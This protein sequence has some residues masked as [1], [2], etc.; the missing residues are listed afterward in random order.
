MV[1]QQ[2]LAADRDQRLRQAGIG[3]AHAHALAA[4]DDRQVAD[5]VGRGEAQP[6][7][8]SASSSA[9]RRT[10]SS[11][12]SVGRRAEPG[13][14]RDGV[15][16]PRHV[17]HPAAVAAG[18]GDRRAGGHA[19]DHRLGQ[20]AD[21]R[22]GALRADVEE[23]PPLGRIRH[24]EPHRADQLGDVQVGL[25]LRAVAQHPQRG[26]SAGEAPREVDQRAVRAAR[27]DHVRKAEDPEA[28]EN[29]WIR[30][31]R[32]GSYVI[33]AVPLRQ[34]LGKLADIDPESSQLKHIKSCLAFTEQTINILIISKSSLKQSLDLLAIAVLYDAIE[35]SLGMRKD[36]YRAG[37]RLALGAGEH[38]QTQMPEDGWCTHDVHRVAHQFDL[39]S[40]YLS[41]NLDRPEPQTSHRN[42][43]AQACKAFRLDESKYSTLHNTPACDGKCGFVSASQDKLA[44]ILLSGVIPL[45]R[46]EADIDPSNI[47]LVPASA[48]TPYVAISHVW[49]HGLGNLHGN[50]LP[51]CQLARISEFVNNLP[52]AS[53][54]R[55]TLFWMDT[56]C[57]PVHHVDA[58][59]AALKFMRRTYKDAD[60][61]LVLDRYLTTTEAKPLLR[62]ECLVRIICSNWTRRLWTLQEG[63]LARVLYFQ[64]SDQAIDIESLTLHM[65]MEMTFICHD[66]SLEYLPIY[67]II[68]ELWEVWKSINIEELRNIINYLAGGLRWRATSVEAD[69]ALCLATLCGLDIEDIIN[70]PDESRMSRF[71]SI[72]PSIPSQ[73]V[74]WSGERL[75]QEGFRWAPSTFLSR[76][77]AI[78]QDLDLKPQS[79]TPKKG[80]ATLTDR[81]LQFWCAGLLLNTWRSPLCKDIFIRMNGRDWFNLR[82]IHSA[83]LIPRWMMMITKT[84]AGHLLC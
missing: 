73:A 55:K 24:D 78:F 13:E 57:F 18:V 67:S 44:A 43:T 65:N 68:S 82:R 79:I 58:A 76:P 59:N 32:D 5:A 19:G 77:D 6:T 46:Y 80:S 11:E 70:G 23:V 49:S 31:G 52:G 20:E 26:R 39:P 38:L 48:G 7:A 41:S 3:L 47:E 33:S 63:A 83:V 84:H 37:G 72:L 36:A 45:I 40:L 64:F 1:L 9:A 22:A 34:L 71:C 81:G 2:R 8:S 50:S 29:K 69:E 16:E 53:G 60:R 30:T 35:K 62:T 15:E 27:P 54:N 28:D 66:R 42:C 17:A 4:G 25:G 10:A 21:P 75:T 14:P 12:L 74:F 51:R 56:I 61:V